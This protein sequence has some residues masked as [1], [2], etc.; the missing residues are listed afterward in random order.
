MEA[1]KNFE[2]NQMKKPNKSLKNKTA[3]KTQML[4]GPYF[5]ITCWIGWKR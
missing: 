4:T 3:Q 5:L 1:R 2:L